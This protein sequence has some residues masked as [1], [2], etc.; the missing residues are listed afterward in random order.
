MNSEN[1]SE[2]VIKKL[3]KQPIALV[4]PRSHIFTV[5]LGLGDM[6]SCADFLLPLNPVLPGLSLNLMSPVLPEPS[7]PLDPVLSELSLDHMSS[8]LSGPSLNVMSTLFS[9]LVNINSLVDFLLSPVT[10]FSSNR[11]PS[12]QG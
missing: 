5:F 3:F 10:N 12:E 4:S 6:N 7:L 9:T 1:L 11:Q 8:V 2:S